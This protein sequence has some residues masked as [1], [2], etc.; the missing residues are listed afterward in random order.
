MVV[1]LL[2]SVAGDGSWECF[3]V[4]AHLINS[5]GQHGLRPECIIRLLEPNG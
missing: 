2:T 1:E 5:D 4:R 3:R